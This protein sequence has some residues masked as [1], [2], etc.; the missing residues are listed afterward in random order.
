MIKFA[1]QKFFENIDTI[2]DNNN[3]NPKTYWKIMKMLIKGTTSTTIPPLLNPVDE[4][5]TDDNS[6]KCE[7]LNNYF[8]S[9]T[10]LEET[11]KNLPYFE[12]KTNSF[13]NN[14]SITREDIIDVIQSVGLNKAS[15]PDGIS[16]RMLKLVT[17]EISI[18]LQI[19]FNE[20]LNC[21]MFPDLWKIAHVIPLFKKGETYLAENYRLISLLS[22]IDKIF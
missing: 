21:S 14:I 17:N 20:S 16:H 7:I 11:D 12:N 3:N 22:C 9:I 19:L 4:S 18:P 1:K 8:V 5:I 2:I 15:G 10:N 13:L 6:L